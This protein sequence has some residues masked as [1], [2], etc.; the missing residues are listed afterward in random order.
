MRNYEVVSKDERVVM[1]RKDNSEN[2]CYGVWSEYFIMVF[3]VMK[4]NVELFKNFF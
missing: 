1:E 3:K 2:C 4:I